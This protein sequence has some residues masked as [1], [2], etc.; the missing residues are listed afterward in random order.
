[1]SPD[2]PWG[3][4]RCQTTRAHIPMS[5]DWENQTRRSNQPLA[6]GQPEKAK[7]TVWDPI[8]ITGGS[9]IIRDDNGDDN[10]HRC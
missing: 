4:G 6:G 5:Q 2:L 7:D 8:I 9:G 1:M 3:Q 10:S